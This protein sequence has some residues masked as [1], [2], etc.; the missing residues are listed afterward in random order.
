MRYLVKA[1][2]LRRRLGRIMAKDHTVS[3]DDLRRRF[4]PV[5]I[6]RCIAFGNMIPAA[7]APG[8]G[9]G[10]GA[11]P[12]P[13]SPSPSEHL[14]QPAAIGSDS[15]PIPQPRTA[16]EVNPGEPARDGAALAKARP[17]AKTKGK[18]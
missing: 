3:M 4:D 1:P 10:V 17:A 6:K 11:Q 14:V 2:W 9:D 7:P 15:G 16:P 18:R 12:T 5:F 13:A 8:T